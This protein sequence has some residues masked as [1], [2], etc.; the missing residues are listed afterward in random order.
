V[1]VILYRYFKNSR[2]VETKWEYNKIPHQ[3]GS[4]EKNENIFSEFGRPI[5]LLG[6]LKYLNGTYK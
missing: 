6:K 5:Q 2:L 3:P 4:G 1:D